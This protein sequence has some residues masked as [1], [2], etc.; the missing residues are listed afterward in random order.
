[1]N[2]ATWQDEYE[3][4]APT[5]ARLNE[6]ARFAIKDAIE[7]EGIKL[8]SLVSRVKTLESLEE[9][10]QRK[11]YSSPLDEAPD[12][13]GL[14][15]VVLFLSDLSRVSE[16]VASVFDVLSSEDKIEGDDDPSTFGYMSKHFEVRIPDT[17]RGPRYEGLREIRFEIQVRTLL[18]DAWANVSHY[19]AYKGDSS[20]PDELRRDFHALSGLFYVAD[21]H[22]ELFFDRA[23]TVR[24]Q[25][26][27]L[28]REK[29]TENVDLNLDTLAAFLE[30]RFPDREHV[31]RAGVASLADDL[32]RFGYKQIADV[33]RLIAQASD[34]FTER[35]KVNPPGNK[36]GA[37]FADV[38]VV[39]I[40]LSLV[41]P[42]YDA[43]LRQHWK[44]LL[45]KS[46]RP[47]Q[48]GAR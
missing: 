39:R 3:R 26:A 30:Q 44:S 31:S 46:K 4:R 8:H 6:E 23:R 34:K 20:I 27:G 9:K 42:A 18:M 48:G 10:C 47:P 5:Y 35:E 21:K 13:V 40:S 15:L 14:R 24:E 29:S 41:E 17:H 7:R 1:M 11:A 25:A 19:L 38:G 28:L 43:Y 32:L 45:N 12:I 2:D 33:E 36:P 16:I 37:R 22:F